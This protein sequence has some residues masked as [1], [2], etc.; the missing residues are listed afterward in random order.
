MPRLRD[1][2]EEEKNLTLDWIESLPNHP[3]YG[4]EIK[5]LLVKA[6]PRVKVAYPEIALEDR[7]DAKA[8]EQ[9]EKL[10]KFLDEQKDKENK[11][12]W[13]KQRETAKEKYDLVDEDIQAVEKFMLDEHV[14][15][16]D[17]AAKHF[18][19][20]KKASA[21]PTN[22]NDAVGVQL[23]NQTGLFQNP[24]AFARNEALKWFQERDRNQRRSN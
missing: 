5:K 18:A 11:A 15:N 9:E 4:P 3:E 6:D 1:L 2:S 22:Y 10:Q 16:Y 19:E 24:V 17:L 8:K 14:G 21:V 23:P 7:F 20:Q 12:Y 13:Q